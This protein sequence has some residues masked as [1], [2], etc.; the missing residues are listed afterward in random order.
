MSNK[1]ADLSPVLK[2]GILFTYTLLFA[3]LY[4]FLTKRKFHRRLKR[5]LALFNILEFLYFRTLMLM[6]L[7]LFF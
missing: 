4:I 2:F 3:S 5:C 1:T 7:N 6:Y